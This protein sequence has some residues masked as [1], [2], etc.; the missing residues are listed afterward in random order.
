LLAGAAQ[1]GKSKGPTVAL[2]C[3]KPTNKQMLEAC[4]LEAEV[5]R[6]L[7]AA[8]PSKADCLKRVPQYLAHCVVGDVLPGAAASAMTSREV[9][10]E[11]FVAM[12]KLEGRPLDQWLYGVDENRLKTVDVSQVLKGPFPGAAFGTRTLAGA[13]RVV[14]QLLSQ[15][16]SVFMPLSGIAYHRDISAHNFL[17]RDGADDVQF[18]LLDFGLAV[19]ASSWHQDFQSRNIS[20]DPRYFT[21]AAWMLI[22]YGHKYLQA[23]PDSSF[24]GQYKSRLDHFSFGLLCLEVLFG[25]W[26]VPDAEAAAK[27]ATPG[28]APKDAIEPA[29]ALGKVRNAWHGVWQ[30]AMRFF[31]MFHAKGFAATREALARSQAVSKYADKLRTLCTELRGAAE[32]CKGSEGGAA[33]AAVLE[34]LAGLVDPRATLA[35]RDLSRLLQPAV[36]A[37]H[38]DLRVRVAGGKD[39]GVPTVDSESPTEPTDSEAAEDSFLAAP[40]E[41]SA[42]DAAL[43]GDEA[44]PETFG[45]PAWAEA[46]EPAAGDKAVSEPDVASSAFIERRGGE[47]IPCMAE[48]GT[49]APTAV[50][51]VTIANP[52]GELA[53]RRN[54]RSPTKPA[55]APMPVRMF[56]HRRNWTVDEAVSLMRGVPDA[57]VGW[58]GSP[59]EPAA[60]SAN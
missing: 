14:V 26:H 59:E 15:M 44:A 23:H 25:L 13:C 51:V 22:V 17:I 52:E 16:S 24:L 29:Q 21:P 33:V 47:A 28:E 56:S 43:A 6:S 54:R 31:Q 4:M 39:Q 18:A 46:A 20:G 2:K 55:T 36:E 10:S 8:L 11:V 3:S 50:V 19:R 30:D 7:A 60:A 1:V 34:V 37:Q 57:A 48:D 49:A 27:L 41:A 32:L 42:G 58:T 9:R 38:A 40:S 5:L 35:W 45:A 53:V 12:T